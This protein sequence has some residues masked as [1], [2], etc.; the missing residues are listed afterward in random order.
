MSSGPNYRPNS[1]NQSTTQRTNF[2]SNGGTAAFNVPP[3]GNIGSSTLPPRPPFPPSHLQQ[4]QF[5]PP[6]LNQS[7]NYSAPRHTSP[8]HPPP[9]L[10][11]THLPPPHM[12]SSQLPPPPLPP[13]SLPPPNHPRPQL[14]QLHC[15]PPNFPPP[16]LQVTSASIQT[17]LPSANPHLM[18]PRCIPNQQQMQL[19]FK[20]EGKLNESDQTSANKSNIHY[21]KLS[22]ED[23]NWLKGFQESKVNH[24]NRVPLVGKPLTENKKIKLSKVTSLASESQ[25]L[26]KTLAKLKVEMEQNASTATPEIWKSLIEQVEQTKDKFNYNIIQLQNPQIM[27]VIQNRRSKRDRLKANRNKLSEEKHNKLCEWKQKEVEI[28]IWRERIIKKEK[29][30]LRE[31]KIIE[32]ADSVLSEIRFKE[33]EASRMIQLLD[34][35]KQLRKTR[36][37]KGDKF[38]YV[39]NCFSD[40]SFDSVMSKM[41]GLVSSHLSDYKLEET[42]LR[43]MM[44]ESGSNQSV[45]LSSRQDK[46]TRSNEVKINNLVFGPNSNKTVT[47]ELDLQSLVGRRHEWDEFLASEENP[48]G[49]SV[50]LGWV[51]PPKNPSQQ[52]IEFAAS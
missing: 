6:T 5:Q 27:K 28:D 29:D 21:N 16:W 8:C 15:P 11:P 49:S 19:N 20:D 41:Q 31:K 43:V 44:E 45:Y 33:T 24:K 13:L 22:M 9:H 47:E 12:Q 4:F 3:A 37:N 52:W 50:P 18:N 17:P 14:T 39:S 30:E 23:M 35:L 40:N 42:T 1:P 38:G 25:T 32:E 7:N 46:D 26:L 51:V 36:T 2:S 10:A 34:A 48:L